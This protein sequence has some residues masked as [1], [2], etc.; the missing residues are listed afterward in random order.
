MWFVKT[1]I[2]AGLMILSGLSWIIPS[3]SKAADL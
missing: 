3:E 2:V 1:L